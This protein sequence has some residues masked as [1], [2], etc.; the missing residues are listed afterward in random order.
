MITTAANFPIITAD[1]LSN[2]IAVYRSKGG[3]P[4]KYTPDIAAEIIDRLA[5]GETLRAICRDH[6]MPSNPTVYDWMAN[7]IEFASA[8]AQARRSQATSF[9][10]EAVDIID[11]A[12]DSNGMAPVQKADKRA[13]IRLSLAKCFDRDQFGDKVQ[14]DINLKGVVVTTSCKELQ[15]L[16]DRQ[17]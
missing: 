4:T 17:R 15:E 3:R 14:Q 6:H 5:A 11:Q 16:M 9:V 8:V 2:A 1:S 13:N 10:E 7:S 12:D